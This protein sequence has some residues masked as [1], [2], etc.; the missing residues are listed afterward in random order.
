MFN[1]VKVNFFVEMFIDGLVVYGYYNGLRGSNIL[2]FSNG[3]GNGSILVLGFSNEIVYVG[4]DLDGL[5]G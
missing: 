2:G 1:K 4:I 3:L 5:G